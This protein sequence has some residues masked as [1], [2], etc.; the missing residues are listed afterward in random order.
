MTN[1]F[2]NVTVGIHGQELPKFNGQNNTKEWWKF[3]KTF[4]EKPECQSAVEMKETQKFWAKS[5][6]IKLADV[7]EDEPPVDCFK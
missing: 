4:T 7:R 5:D 3:R 2:G 1:K 6:E